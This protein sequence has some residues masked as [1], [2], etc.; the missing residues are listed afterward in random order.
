MSNNP[1]LFN[2]ALCGVFG[3]INT[4]RSIDSTLAGDYATQST[5]AFAFATLL[6]GQIA[7]GSYSQADGLM[8]QAIVQEV[9]S[10]K[11]LAGLNLTTINAIIAAFNVARASLDP[12]ANASI[13]PLTAVYYV[14]AGFGGTADGSIAKPFPTIAAAVAAALAVPYAFVS[15]LLAPGDYS[16]EGTISIVGI[17]VSMSAIGGVVLVDSIDS[18]SFVILEDIN[19]IA[20]VEASFLYLLPGNNGWGIGGNVG[21][22]TPL[23]GLRA[24]GYS[25]DGSLSTIGGTVDVAGATQAENV[26]FG[27]TLNTLGLEAINCRFA[28]DVETTAVT[29]IDTFKLRLCEFIGGAHT[30][31]GPVGAILGFDQW[32]NEYFNDSAWT[33][34]DIVKRVVGEAP[35]AEITVTVPVLLATVIGSVAVSMAGTPLEGVAVGSGIVANAPSAGITG[36]GVLAN[37]FVDSAGSVTYVFIGPTTGGDQDFT[38]T[39]VS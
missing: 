2:A 15:L 39:K 17:G 25:P 16:A 22:V 38:T 30:L 34:V 28:D 32:S 7:I 21:S 33:L 37:A 24:F 29:N 27:G 20:D 11:G 19:T 4:S 35:S 10:G 5:N 31:T 12:A 14:D 23:T 1:I 6:D 9:V 36:G 26:L 13:A 8:L 3:G 18:D